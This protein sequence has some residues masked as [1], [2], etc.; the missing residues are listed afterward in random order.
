MLASDC[1]ESRTLLT[2]GRDRHSVRYADGP[3][4]ANASHETEEGQQAFKEEIGAVVQAA[5]QPGR[6]T[7]RGTRRGEMVMLNFLDMLSERYSLRL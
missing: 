1:N 2:Q 7:V 4:H 3:R 5:R 6:V